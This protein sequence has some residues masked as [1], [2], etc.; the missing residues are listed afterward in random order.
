[1][2]VSSVKVW[3]SVDVRFVRECNYGFGAQAEAQ[4]DVDDDPVTAVED[5]Y[6]TVVRPSILKQMSMMAAS[7]QLFKIAVTME[8]PRIIK[9][10]ERVNNAV[11]NPPRR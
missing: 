3:A 1:M 9:N 6:K 10:Y 7:D 2:R 8:R 4:L 5:L 11:N